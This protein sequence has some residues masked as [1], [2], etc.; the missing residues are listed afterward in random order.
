MEITP[1]V[2]TAA[3][4]MRCEHCQKLRNAADCRPVTDI[5]YDYRIG[6]HRKIRMHVCIDT[7]ANIYDTGLA[8]IQLQQKLRA[9][10]RR[11]PC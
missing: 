9:Q 3:R 11:S 10:Q 6:R 1:D 5:R 8:I 2:A 7:C 4:P